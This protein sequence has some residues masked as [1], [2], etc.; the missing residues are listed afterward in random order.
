MLALVVIVVSAAYRG[1]RLSSDSKGAPRPPA[2]VP[3]FLWAFLLLVAIH[4]MHWIPDA[5]QPVIGDVSRGCLVV[6]IAALG[7]KTSFQMLLHTGWRPFALLLI[8]TFWLACVL[9]VAILIVKL[10]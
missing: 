5:A 7:V 9:L 2:L 6:A 8:E 3:W 4:S 10:A 1:R